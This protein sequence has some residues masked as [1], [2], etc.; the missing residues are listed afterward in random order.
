M[1]P[2]FV[3]LLSHKHEASFVNFVMINDIAN[4]AQPK[5]TSHQRNVFHKYDQVCEQKKR[6]SPRWEAPNTEDPEMREI[7][8]ESAARVLD[9]VE[10]SGLVMLLNELVGPMQEM[11]RKGL[12]VF[13]YFVWFWCCLL[14]VY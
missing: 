12:I 9:A 14:N 11:R 2:L 13:N 5:P 10:Q 7:S 3:P 1:Q 8:V 4:I 6:N